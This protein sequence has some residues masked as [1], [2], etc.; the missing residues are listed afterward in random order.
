MIARGVPKEIVSLI[1]GHAD[2]DITDTYISLTPEM[3]GDTLQKINPPKEEK[4]RAK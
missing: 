1:M 3:F 4:N 2:I